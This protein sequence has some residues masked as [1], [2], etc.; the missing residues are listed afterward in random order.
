MSADR[1]GVFDGVFTLAQIEQAIRE[2]WSEDTS[3]PRNGEQWSAEN[4]S[5]GQCDIT[6]LVVHDLVG[7]ELLAAE[8]YLRGERVEAHMWN[9]LP[10]G[11][12]L[13][14][15][16]E[17]FRSGEVI[18]D[19]VARERPQRFDPAHPRYHRYETYLVLSARVR[20]RLGLTATRPRS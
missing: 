10:S 12:E 1:Q 4:P 16:R 5:L 3:D 19:P 18:G 9:R 15:T 6:S 11:L 20:E 13:D 17:Q 14:L 2:S 7:G 8:V